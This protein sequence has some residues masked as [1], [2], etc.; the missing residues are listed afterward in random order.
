MILNVGV[1]GGI[2]TPQRRGADVVCDIDYPKT[3]LENFV[4]CDAHN[5]PFRNKA[6]QL[7][8]CHNVLEHVYDPWK[9][10]REMKRVSEIVN[11]RQDV[12][13][14]FA[15]YATP[16]HYWFQLPD[17]KF[18]PYPRTR[19][20]IVFSKALRF[21]FSKFF[22]D[23]LHFSVWINIMSQRYEVNL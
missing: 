22:A 18:L 3:R 2:F 6:F 4:R 20:G 8:L 16:E 17:L 19:I 13:W 11:I 14:S 12:W 9:V 10:M 21:V 5:L 7:T 23:T 1:G 15:S